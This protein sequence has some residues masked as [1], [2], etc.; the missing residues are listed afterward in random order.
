MGGLGQWIW[1][2]LT[3]IIGG[4]TGGDPSRVGWDYAARA[5]AA[6]TPQGGGQFAPTSAP[7]GYG[8]VGGGGI[9]PAIWAAF[10][11]ANAT[12]P[13]RRSGPY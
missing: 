3:S 9:D 13:V 8:G 10:V 2:G 5:A 4:A 7:A 1:N 12:V 6:P 11:S